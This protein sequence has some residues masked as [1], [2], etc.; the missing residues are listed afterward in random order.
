MRMAGQAS[1]A[2][3]L[4]LEFVLR[5]YDPMPSHGLSEE[6]RGRRRRGY[7]GCPLVSASRPIGVTATVL[8]RWPRAA[9]GRRALRPLQPLLTSTWPL[10]QAW[11]FS[12]LG[13]LFAESSLSFWECFVSFRLLHVLLGALFHSHFGFLVSQSQPWG[14]CFFSWVL[15]VFLWVFL[16]CQG[17]LG[18]VLGIWNIVFGGH[19]SCWKPEMLV[20]VCS[21]R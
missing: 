11:S 20:L 18:C 17:A 12:T 21:S 8:M 1:G 2:E 10:L 3:P 14:C 16:F 9:A 7:E 6:L 4:A 5:S 15:Q 13:L 19:G